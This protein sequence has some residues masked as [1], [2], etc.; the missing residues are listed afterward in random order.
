MMLQLRQQL[1]TICI[2]CLIFQEGNQIMRFDQLI[3]ECNMKKI[4]LK[5]SY[6]KC[7]GETRSRPLY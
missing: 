2:Y 1:I 5:I 3:I 6:T 4:F 7:S